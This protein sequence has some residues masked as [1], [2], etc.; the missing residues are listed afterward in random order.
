M[1]QT[2]NSQL[3]D[4]VALRPSCPAT[5]TSSGTQPNAYQTKAVTPA[6]AAGRVRSL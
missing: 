2:T 5:E 1:N 3:E 6:R 4:W